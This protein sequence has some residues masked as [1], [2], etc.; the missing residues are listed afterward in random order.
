[1]W[2]KPACPEPP[3][4]TH[5]RLV[6]ELQGRRASQLWFWDRRGLGTIRLLS[7]DDCEVRLG[8]LHV[9]PDALAISADELRQRLHRSHRPIKVAL[10]DQK[11]L[12]GIGNLYASEILHVAK[13]LPTRSCAVL[14][15]LEWNKLHKA[16]QEVLQAAIEY[17]GSTLEDGT[18][19][20]ALN[21]NGRY[22][23]HHRVYKRAGE[24][25]P[26]CRTGTVKRIVQ[27]QRSTFFCKTCQR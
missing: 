8:P 17:E 20:N 5:L 10:L 13:I 25:C 15:P 7:R 24:R 27:A 21:Q 14:R 3:H 16:T 26:R 1:M 2:G 9:G 6:L 22:Q 18:Y 12:A 11:T 4:A 19:R 23:N